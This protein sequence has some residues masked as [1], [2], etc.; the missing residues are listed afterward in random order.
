MEARG[1]VRWTA[2]HL[3]CVSCSPRAVAA[4]VAGGADI[5]AATR[6]GDTPLHLALVSVLGK[7]YPELR[8]PSLRAARKML[9][10]LLGAGADPLAR[11]AKGETRA[12]A[13]RERGVS[14]PAALLERAPGWLRDTAEYCV[15]W[16]L[17]KLTEAL[18]GRERFGCLRSC[19]CSQA[20]WTRGR[21][22][23][24][25]CR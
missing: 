14:T 1:N 21:R 18:T 16:A 23:R 6:S 17:C 11:N 22:Y 3:A 15:V 12:D 20:S 2:L 10:T 7:E 9:Q 8:P 4:L 19:A 5:N 13:A 25:C 24:D